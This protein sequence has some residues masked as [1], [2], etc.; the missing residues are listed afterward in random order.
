MKAV[1]YLV[2]LAQTG[3]GLPVLV[4]PVQGGPLR[5]VPKQEVLTVV[6]CYFRILLWY[7]LIAV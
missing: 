3:F 1:P 4:L 7:R 6:G 2:V 5:F